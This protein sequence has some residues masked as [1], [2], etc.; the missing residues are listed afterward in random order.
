MT[1]VK[2][3]PVKCNLCDAD[4]TR[5]LVQDSVWRGADCYTFDIVQCR[6][7]GLIYTNP[8][9]KSEVFGNLAG[10][11]ARGDA[12]VANRPIYEA[13]MATICHRLNAIEAGEG[14]QVKLLDIGC[15]FGD[16]LT[17]A[18]AQ[19]WDVSG[20][21]ISPR[22]AAEARARGLTVY[23]GDL[24]GLELPPETYDVVTMWDVIEHLDNPK[25]FL[26]TIRPLL[27]PNGLL[28]FHTGNARFQ[29][30][31]ARVLSRLLPNQGPFLIP[32]QHLYHFD[33]ASARAMLAA[34]G[35]ELV[36]VFSCRTLHYRN[37]WKRLALDAYNRMA[38]AIAGL[39]GPLWT[40]AMGVLARKP[41]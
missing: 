12:A 18:Q 15:A 14:F 40:S 29:I 20:V 34:T 27:R 4:N 8:Q 13:G 17:Y 39:G 2:W 23:E 16:F 31:K 3:I 33:P 32:Y 1:Q 11:G 35:F 5:L 22:L 37:R 10:G 28:F 25:G 36:V 41:R 6:C 24:A 9:A 7:C 26:T 30:F 21:E 38:G 19:G